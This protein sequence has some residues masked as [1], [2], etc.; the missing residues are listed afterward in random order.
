MELLATIKA[1]QA[2]KI[3]NAEVHIYS[4]SKYVVDAVAK[5]WVFG[6]EKK[7]FKDKKNQDMWVEF[8]KQYRIHTPKLHWIKGHNNHLQNERCDRLAV[9]ASKKP[10]LKVDQWFEEQQKGGATIFT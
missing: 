10:N 3:K 9:E 1:M 8:L 4:D 6:W 5:G 2:I 7:G